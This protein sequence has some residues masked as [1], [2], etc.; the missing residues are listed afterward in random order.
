MR[1][2]NGKD[3]LRR[4][5]TPEGI[6]ILAKA[7]HLPPLDLR[8]IEERSNADVFAKSIVVLQILWF[9]L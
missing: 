2:Y 6:A 9:A 5:L 4:L 3:I 7:G 8:D 1:K